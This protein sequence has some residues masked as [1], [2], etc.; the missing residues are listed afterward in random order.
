MII[1]RFQENPTPGPSGS[2]DIQGSA[3]DSSAVSRFSIFFL[4]DL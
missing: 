3:D 2:K 1:L 4:T